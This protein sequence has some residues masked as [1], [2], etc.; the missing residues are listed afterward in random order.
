MGTLF[1]TSSAVP[2]SDMISSEELYTIL[3][4]SNSNIGL[5]S[6]TFTVSNS[7]EVGCSLIIP[8]SFIH[9]A[10]LNANLISEILTEL[11]PMNSILTE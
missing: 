6:I 3:S 4:V 7:R 1:N 2:L 10:P 11:K 9:V 8:K 5:S